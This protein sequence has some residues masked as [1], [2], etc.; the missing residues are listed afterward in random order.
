MEYRILGPL[1]IMCGPGRLE[2][3]GARQQVVV[4][5]LLLNPNRQVSM[6]R[7]LEAVYGE[8]LPSTARSQVQI[9]ISS[10]RRLFAECHHDEVI[11]T[12][13]GGYEIQVG[14]GELD[15]GRFEELLANA[16]EA[17]E[18]GDYGLAVA[19]FRDADR[20]WRG[21]ALV[22]IDSS[23]VRSA[24]SRLDELGIGANEDRITLELDLGRHHELIGELTEMVGEYPLRE[25]LRGQ[26]MLALYRCDRVAEALQ[27]YQVTRRTMIEELGIDPSDRL[28]GLERAILTSDP[29]LDLPSGHVD[30]QVKR[31]RAPNLLPA[32]I[33]DFTGRDEQVSQIAQHLAGTSEQVRHAVPVVV[34][35][36]KGG[37]GK[38]TLAVHAAHAIADK[39]RDGQLFADLHG[40]GAHPVGPM[41]VLE[42]FLRAFG[43][44]GSQIPESVD[45]RAEMYRNLLAD[46]RILVV[47]DDAASESQVLPLLPGSATAGVII[48][49]RNMLTGIAGVLR[50]E[51]DVLAA[52]N[53]VDLLARIAGVARI[54]AE[55]AAAVAVAAH[56][57]YL[58]LA[59]RIAGARLAAHPHWSVRQLAERLSD[60]ANR[61]DELRHD[62]M[63]IRP[64]ISLTYEG[65]SEEA[66]KL[67]RRLALL[68]MPVFSSWFGAALLDQ[69]VDV[70]GDLLDDLVRAQLIEV[71]RGGAGLDSQYRFHDLIRV[72][73]RER[74][75]A[76]D[77]VAERRAA[78]ERALG[79]LLHLSDAA[80]SSYYGGD[81]ARL[82]SGAL[83]W[84]LP[85]RLV[86]MLVSDPLAWYERERAALVAGVR[87]AAQAGLTEL[88]WSLASS[89]VPMFESRV[90]L[91]D[92]RETHEIALEAVRKAHDVRGEAAMLYHL[93]SLHITQLWFDQAF[94]ELTDAARL[95]AEVRDDRGIAHATFHLA[96]IDRLSGRLDDAADRYLQALA[97]FRARSDPVATA[98]VLHGLAQ[99]QMERSEPAEVMRLLS[100]ALSLCRA[101]PYA[102]LEAQILHRLG[103]A[104]L[105]TEDLG[106]ATEA[107][108]GALAITNKIGDVIGA[109]YALQGLGV[110]LTRQGDYDGARSALGRAAQLAGSVDEQMAEARAMIGLS[111]L[112][113]AFGD[114][115]KAAQL[116]QRA[117]SIFERLNA[118]LF[119]ARA[120]ARLSEAR[121]ALG[122]VAA[123]EAAAAEAAALRLKLVGQ[124][125]PPSLAAG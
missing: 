119:R 11:S 108:E 26:L 70:A 5:M 27:V 78:L 23:L 122:E 43:V 100:E 77:P 7:L 85:G 32:D 65:T 71:A 103:E 8:D 72:F 98:S 18:L 20:L 4:A 64:S 123:A 75:V 51:V 33:A 3:H 105:Q 53:S 76:E 2:L 15:S 125:R 60:E 30:G 14:E 92:W 107:F 19:R 116:G 87:Q 69:P 38:T 12:R 22:G 120:L 46:Q 9:S 17:R 55:S 101:V 45:E 31:E 96:S 25:A 124:E 1:E 66:R 40:A 57:G 63:G 28:Q 94:G 44:A 114:A 48:S 24:A 84:A 111:E 102:R 13:A 118:P 36:G 90:Y 109:S 95:F 73:A 61:L 86:E 104:C 82:T 50:I 83:R 37:I 68:D 99:V 49:S 52:E 106:R 62:D 89:A 54:C 29:A 56:C 67:F 115:R 41:H 58:P 35:V 42:R 80:R 74:L 79:A 16:R 117:A 39:F 88:C 81:Y 34:V 112:E 10:L 113:L 97:V 59:L 110:A 47:L 121:A 6:G 93:G 91:D 21:P